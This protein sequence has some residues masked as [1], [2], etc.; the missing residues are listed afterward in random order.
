MPATLREV[1][2]RAGLSRATISRILNN[3]GAE[4]RIP[5]STQDRVR[6]I[7]EELNYRPNRVAQ[8]LVTG[9][10]NII[11]L[12]IP[13]LHNPFFMTLLEMA[14]VRAFQSGYDVLPDSAFQLR[15]NYGVRGK[16]S[17]WPVDGIVAWLAAD[18]HVSDYLDAWTPDM[19]TVYIG[20][21]RDDA[22]DYVAVDREMG[23][24]QL[25]EHMVARGYKRI[26]YIYPWKDLQPLDVRYMF[27]ETIC[28]DMN[29][30]PERI[31]LEL[32]EPE[33]TTRLVT[34]AGL[35]E[36]GL[37]TGITLGGRAASDRPDAVICH[38]DL[39]AI[40][41]YH[42]L[43]RCGIDVPREIG[44]AGFDGIDEGLYLD[45]ALTTVVSPGAAIVEEAMTMLTDRLEHGYGEVPE[46]RQVILDSALRIGGTT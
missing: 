9:R 8:G 28:S 44:V 11:G 7:A 43:V 30:E 25:M 22:S 27:Y 40:G 36:A 34:Q 6:K 18:K 14:E 20:Y 23:I 45:K 29:R 31:H 13:G 10:S 19:P 2:D 24:R 41:V 33:N 12:M 38:N 17:G 3:R 42:G 1:S 16:L 26:A 32:M 37:K 21:Q 5:Q 35:R 46:P 4:S 15:N 39:V